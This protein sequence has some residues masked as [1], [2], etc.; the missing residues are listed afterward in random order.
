MKKKALSPVIATVLLVAIVIAIALIVFLWIRNMKGE[1][2]TKFGGENVET[3]CGE[4]V[5][6]GD[7]TAPTL[8]IVNNGNVG[9]FKM[10]L[11][12]YREGNSETVSINSFRSLNP[13]ET[14]STEE[15][16]DLSDAEKILLIPILLGDSEDGERAFVCEEDYGVEILI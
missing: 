3:V 14:F 8:S 10:K 12:V 1:V 4:V 2:I 6:T 9:I 7:Y 15:I 5:F 11:K 13:G 16:G